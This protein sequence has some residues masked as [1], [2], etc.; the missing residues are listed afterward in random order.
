M[1]LYLVEKAKEDIERR[2]AQQGDADVLELDGKQ[3][4]H[5]RRHGQCHRDG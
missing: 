5:R 3:R 4:R 2:A 1:T